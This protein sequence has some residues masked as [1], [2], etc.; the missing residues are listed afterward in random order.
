MRAIL[1]KIKDLYYKYY[2]ISPLDQ[3]DSA[4]SN[5]LFN[6]FWS[7]IWT[8]LILAVFVYMIFNYKNNSSE[9]HVRFL[10]RGLTL[11]AFFISYILS[12]KFKNVAR[13]KAYILKNIPIYTILVCAMSEASVF[14]YIEENH[15]DGILL[16]I[17][18]IFVV[19]S[20]LSVTL[21]LFIIILA[22][23]I[24]MFPGFF[25]FW[26]G[27]GIF[28]FTVVLIVM[29]SIAFYS[30][31]KLKRH[32]ALLKTQK[33]SLVAKTFG[34]FTLLF[35]RKIVK[36]SRSKS[37]E[38]IAYLIYKNG[39]SVQTKELIAALWGDNA[40][41]ARYGASLRQLVADVKH[42]FSEL[43]IQNFFVA[44][45]NNFRINPEVVQCDYYDF[46]AGE[47]KATKAFAGEFM[48]Q[49]SWAE[50]T[51]A[52]LERKVLA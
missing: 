21:P 14:F 28:N 22:T 38:F 41:S 18:G 8:F 12:K 13:E 48:S 11:L 27:I 6:L 46:L 32:L 15:F 42:T 39:S 9:Y 50:D 45:Y 52:F 30:R 25:I 16:F 34:N 26:N 40:D 10:F 20:V 51:V 31:L 19:L 23:Y 4:E 44:E 33:K 2:Y 35:D 29:L 37:T 3:A 7:F 17:G 47:P 36:F 49:Y 1:K 24:A 43:E 5:R